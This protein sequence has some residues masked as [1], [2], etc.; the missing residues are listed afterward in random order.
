MDGSLEGRNLTAPCHV[1]LILEQIDIL[2]LMD[3]GGGYFFPSFTSSPV[4]TEM[5]RTCVATNGA[6]LPSGRIKIA[7]IVIR[8]TREMK[9]YDCVWELLAWP[10]LRAT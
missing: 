4:T 2:L 9:G 1:H 10:A 5:N 3:D 7:P 6:W 8:E